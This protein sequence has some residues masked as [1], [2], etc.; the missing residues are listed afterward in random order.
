MFS[1]DSKAGIAKKKNFTAHEVPLGTKQ[2]ATISVKGLLTM[3]GYDEP[4]QLFMGV[5]F[6]MIIMNLCAD[7]KDAF[8]GILVLFK[9]S[10][11]LVLL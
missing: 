1:L 10:C 11:T 7:Y 6:H 4:T 5:F 2:R 8:C 9:D 3:Y